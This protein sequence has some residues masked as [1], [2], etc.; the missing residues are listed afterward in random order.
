MSSLATCFLMATISHF[1]E[2]IQLNGTPCAIE[3]KSVNAD[4]KVTFNVR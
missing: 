2:G 3:I 1:L 4:L